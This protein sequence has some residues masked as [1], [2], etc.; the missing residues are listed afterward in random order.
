VFSTIGATMEKL[1]RETREIIFIFN[2]HKLL[3]LKAIFECRQEDICG[4]DLVNNLGITKDLLSY[5][6]KSLRERGFLSEVKCGTKKK[7]AIHK[8]KYELVRQIL[9]TAQLIKE[10]E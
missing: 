6:I 10:R 1:S 9:I 3:V 5:H 2:K 8:E 4:C 7:Y